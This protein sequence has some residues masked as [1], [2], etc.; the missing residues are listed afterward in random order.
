MVKSERKG[1]KKSKDIESIA[2]YATSERADHVLTSLS[3]ELQ[4]KAIL[5]D[6]VITCD[7][8]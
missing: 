6:F 1:I 8:T 3:I 4:G 7:S 2:P 5:E